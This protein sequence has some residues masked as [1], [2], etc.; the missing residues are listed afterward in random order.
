MVATR[1]GGIQDQVTDDTGV[2][3]DDPHHLDAYG[4]AVAALL[5]DPERAATL[6]EAARERVRDHFLGLG[7]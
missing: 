7:T 4:D 1:I 3:I 6:G 5:D 2:L